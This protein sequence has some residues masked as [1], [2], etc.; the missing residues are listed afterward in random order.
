MSAFT[1]DWL[2]LNCMEIF[3]YLANQ[4]KGIPIFE[5][6]HRKI[7]KNKESCA[8]FNDSDFQPDGLLSNTH[9]D[10]VFG[11]KSIFSVRFDQNDATFSIP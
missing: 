9:N 6:D 3:H 1:L 2:R 7:D 5:N 4:L 8:A 10:T 11:A